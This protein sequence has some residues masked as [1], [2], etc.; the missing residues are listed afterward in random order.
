MR[1]RAGIVAA[2][3]V[4]VDLLFMVASDKV[5]LP[6]GAV[7]PG[8]ITRMLWEPEATGSRHSSVRPARR[9]RRYQPV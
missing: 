9:A 2:S 1:L 6:D 8:L 5:E 7:L 4:V 3:I